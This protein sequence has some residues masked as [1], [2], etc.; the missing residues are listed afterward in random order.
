MEIHQIFTKLLHCVP[1]GTLTVGIKGLMREPNSPMQFSVGPS[2]KDKTVETL[3][4]DTPLTS[5]LYFFLV[6]KVLRLLY[7]H[8]LQNPTKDSLQV[9]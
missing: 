1:I 6:K 4:W 3:N 5:T 9:L 8:N 2:V 7:V